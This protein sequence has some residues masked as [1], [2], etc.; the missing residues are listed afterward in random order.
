MKLTRIPGHEAVEKQSWSLKVSTVKQL[1]AY[2]EM[3]VK[4]TG[5]DV[6]LK[7]VV[8]QML[9]DFMADDKTFQK[10]FRQLQDAQPVTKNVKAAPA[11]VSASDTDSSTTNTPAVSEV[12]SGFR[13][14]SAA[15]SSI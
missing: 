5:A 12:Q 4:A 1:K 10:A 2:H 14:T 8:E 7:D 3:Y 9:L 13:L 15:P 11:A 6:A